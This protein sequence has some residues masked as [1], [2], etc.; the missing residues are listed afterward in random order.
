MGDALCRKQVA[1]LRAGSL[2]GILDGIREVAAV[3][4]RDPEPLLARLRELRAGVARR[5]EGAPR[6]RVACLEWIEPIFHM[7]NW[8]PE[9]VDAAGGNSVLG[10]AGE[11]SS[12]ITWE[13]VVQA[14][15]DV[16]LVAPCGFD[17][18]RTLREMPSFAARPGWRELRAVREGRVFA[19][20]GNLYFNRSSPSAFTSICV[21]AEMLHPD[22]F[23]PEHA[24][25]WQRF[26]G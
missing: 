23:P 11:H 1:A 20:D 25:S 8:G 22:R 26:G 12:A 21:L 3:I 5:L 19:A 18:P 7:G 16:L 2:D 15:P 10:T 6:P 24:S 13:R 14:D 9:I 17:L 4:H